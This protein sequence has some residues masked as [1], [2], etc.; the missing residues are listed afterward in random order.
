MATTDFET[1]KNELITTEFPDGVD[2]LAEAALNSLRRRY[3]E[4]WRYYHT[5]EHPRELFDVLHTYRD[6]VEDPSAVGWAFMYHDAVYDPTA[7]R[8]LNEELSARL[9]E[10]D[11]GLMGLTALGAK[12]AHFTRATANHDVEESDN[13][14][15]FFLDAD[16]AILGTRPRRY[17][18]YALDIRKEYKESVRQDRDYCLGRIA[19]LG[20]LATRVEGKRVYQTEL[21]RAHCE[22][23]A[24]ENIA[25]ETLMLEEFINE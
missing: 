21:F 19:V 8:G 18:R 13:D 5:F 6:E 11:F 17:D 12:V 20:G 16:L 14:L 23:Q 2:A 24:Q 1:I 7:E 22:A 9:A 15:R 10:R 25:R 3:E 4:P